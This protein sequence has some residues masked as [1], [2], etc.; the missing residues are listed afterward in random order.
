MKTV[1]DYVR[2]PHTTASDHK[3]SRPGTSVVVT[4]DS[5]RVLL[6]RCHRSGG[7]RFPG[8]PRE[9]GESFEET[10]RREVEDTAEVALGELELLGVCSGP[11]YFHVGS[12]DQVFT[13]TAVYTARMAG[14]GRAELAFFP[15][16]ELPLDIL[17]G[18]RSVL[19]TYVTSLNRQDYSSA[20]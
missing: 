14:R 10:V 11:D 17:P 5:G 7:W 9:A 15:L 1:L 16:N 4:D 12:G 18:E 6:I 20:A 2:K 3:Q 8:A 13:V 19:A